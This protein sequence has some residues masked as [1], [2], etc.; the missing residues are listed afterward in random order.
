MY[1]AVPLMASDLWPVYDHEL[2]P[3]AHG[4]RRI[5][6]TGNQDVQTTPQNAIGRRSPSRP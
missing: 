1:R 5:A 2:H 3:M 6:Y 4:V